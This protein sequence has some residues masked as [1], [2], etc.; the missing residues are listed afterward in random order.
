MD[1]LFAQA[2]HEAVLRKSGLLDPQETLVYGKAV[3]KGDVWQGVYLDDLLVTY[4]HTLTYP[5]PLDGSFVLP[6]FQV[7]DPNSILVQK[8]EGAYEEAHLQRAVHKAFRGSS[9]FKAWGGEVDGV[10][11]CIGAPK[12]VRQQL[13]FLIMLVCEQGWASKNVLEKIN[14]FLAFAFQFRREFFALQHKVY[15]FVSKMPAGRW[16]RLPGFVTDEL[17]SLSL[18]LPFAHWNMRRR[19]SESV[20]ATDATPMSGGAVRASAPPALVEEFWRRSEVRGAPVRLDRSIFEIATEPIEVSQ[21]AS[22]IAEAL[23]WSVT[24]SYVFRQTSHINLQECRALRR[25]VAKLAGKLSSGAQV[26]I[27]LNDSMVVTCAV[28]KGRSSSYKLN[29]ILR[30]MLPYLLFGDIVLAVLWVE[31]ESNYADHPSRF[32]PLPPPRAAPQ[33]L[34]RYG[35]CGPLVMCGLE[36]CAGSARITWA[37]R[38]AGLNMRDPVDLLWGEDVFDP[39]LDELIKTRQVKWLWLAPPCSSFSPLRNLDRSGPLRVVPEGDP[40]NQ[41]VQR[42]SALWGRALE[43]A[44]L[45]LEADGYF[46]LEHP[47]NSKAWSLRCTELFLRNPPEPGSKV[48]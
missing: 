13:W 43:L 7:D 16:I 11:G 22:V 32:R 10:R 35:L 19:I 44:H 8:A 29:G 5:I 48:A 45:I 15:T 3:P 36:I 21:F 33:W 40:S 6:P 18:H 34:A 41:E 39:R 46:I 38:E 30:G 2:T 31:T 23:P 9:H 28:A 12:A 27:C 20:L 25:E 47:R 4:R 17:R 1:V 37:H 14:G 26:Q 24:A 42:G